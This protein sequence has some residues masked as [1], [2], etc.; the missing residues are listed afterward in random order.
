[1]IFQKYVLK[2]SFQRFYLHYLH[3]LTGVVVGVEKDELIMEIGG[4]MIKLSINEIWYAEHK[5]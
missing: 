1:V 3:Q 4:N 2:W 5:P